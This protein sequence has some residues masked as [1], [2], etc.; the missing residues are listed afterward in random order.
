MA[1]GSR[2][3]PP[4]DLGPD[5]NLAS[6][7]EQDQTRQVLAQVIRQEGSHVVAS[8]AAATGD[9]ELAEDLVQDATVVA[10]EKWTS[11]G[12]P[13][14]PAS[15]LFTT[16]RNRAI[17]RL[18]REAN[19]RKKL[20]LIAR[21][22]ESP[23]DERLKLIFICCHPAL[24]RE[25]QVALT[26]RTVCGLTAS[27]IARAFLTKEA[28]IAQRLV[29]ARKK[30]AEAGIPYKAPEADELEERLEEVLGVIYLMFNE[31]YLTSGGQDAHRPFLVAEAEWLCRILTRL[32]PTEPEVLGLYALIQL[33]RAREKGR[34]DPSGRLV[35]LRHQDRSL[36]DKATISA[37]ADLVVRASQMGRPG[38]YQIQ[39]AI[40]ACHAESPSW[41]ETDWQQI[42][43]LYDALLSHAPTPVVRLNRAV[44]LRYVQGAEPALVEVES[45]S[46]ELKDYRL[47]HAIRA[48]FLRDVGRQEEA[49][50]ADLI[51]LQLTENAAERALLEDRL[52]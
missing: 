41:E 48:D 44:A 42:L 36:W 52:A 32:I 37:A 43:L 4:A 13:I 6:A 7:M 11:E 39:A 29:R 21:T 15:W 12:I 5:P 45:V 26:L 10:L 50:E 20:E 38:Q 34:F 35:L 30:I 2:G 27:E 24:S 8:L 46:A 14:K 3:D 22:E 33:H 40:I 49:R 25:S 17:D 18:R 19:Y 23:R 47:Y 51:A 28:T 16:A 9:L 1:G 31:G